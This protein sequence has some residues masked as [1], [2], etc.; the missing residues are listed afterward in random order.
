MSEI[1]DDLRRARLAAIQN[2]RALAC[3]LKGIWSDET[4][5]TLQKLVLTQQALE[6]IDAAIEL[7]KKG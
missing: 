5:E 2:R 7:E 3:R 6:A 1:L 4:H